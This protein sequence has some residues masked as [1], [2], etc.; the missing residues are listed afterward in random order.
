MPIAAFG[1]PAH[2]VD[3]NTALDAFTENGVVDDPDFDAAADVFGIV[4]LVTSINYVY[5]IN[6]MTFDFPVPDAFVWDVTAALQSAVDSNADHVSF[7][8]AI[9]TALG[10]GVSSS[11]SFEG[12]SIDVQ[13][14]P[15]PTTLAL[16]GIGMV[17]LRCRRINRRA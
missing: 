13:A 8:L 5:D 7:R 2:P 12:A 4:G 1:A 6:T 15:E 3:I 17:A 9:S 11:I 16:C 14:M 10:T